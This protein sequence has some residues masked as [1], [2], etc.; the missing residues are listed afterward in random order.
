MHV[1]MLTVVFIVIFL[2][3]SANKLEMYTISMQHFQNFISLA[4]HEIMQK[5]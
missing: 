5:T 3:K 4:Q 1:N 2:P